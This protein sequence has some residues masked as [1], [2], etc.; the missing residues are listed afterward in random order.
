MA[1]KAKKFE[2]QA[3]TV[4]VGRSLPGLSQYTAFVGGVIPEY[5]KE[6]IAQKPA[7][8]GLIVPANEVQEARKNITKKGHILNYY[9]SKLNDK[10]A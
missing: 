7:I 3:T 9:A 1:K 2:S 4:Y 6:K 10:E 5:V 8:A